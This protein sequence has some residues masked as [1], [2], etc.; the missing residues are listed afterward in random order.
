MRSAPSVVTSDGTDHF[1]AENPSDQF[2]GNWTVLNAST[3]SSAIYSTDNVSGTQ[4]DAV[5]V[6]SSSSDARLAFNSEL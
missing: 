2:D 1:R 3:R 4:G 6:R 5:V